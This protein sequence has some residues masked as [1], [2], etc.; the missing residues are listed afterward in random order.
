MSKSLS[1]G[2]KRKSTHSEPSNTKKQKVKNGSDSEEEVHS[3][4]DSSE[5]SCSDEEGEEFTLPDDLPKMD[6]LKFITLDSTVSIFGKRNT[7]KSF[8]ARYLLDILKDY[9]PWG[10]CMT[11]TPQNGWWQMM[12]PEKKIY[13]GWRPDL[14]KKIMEIQRKRIRMTDINPFVF[15][16]LDDIVSDQ[17]L[18]YDPTLRELYYEGR[19]FGIFILICAQY[20]Y[21]LPPGNRANTDF[22]VTFN[23]HQHRQIKQLHED[24]MTEYKNWQFVRRDMQK[25]LGEHECLIVNQRDPDLRG[26][27]RYHW[28]KATEPKPFYLGTKQ[29]WE[30][31]DWQ[32]QQK[33]WKPIVDRTLEKMKKM[34]AEMEWKHTVDDSGFEDGKSGSETPLLERLIGYGG[35]IPAYF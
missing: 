9:F 1:V 17:A 28:D 13:K 26:V 18:R 16:I 15:I 6:W 21:G 8:Y 7:G 14:I 10:W 5:E 30:G 33:D 27:E 32:Q 12:I 35:F 20:V 3:H 24:Y 22:C 25:M 4:G 11:N 23:Q 31:S 34:K 2:K 19:H 29:Y